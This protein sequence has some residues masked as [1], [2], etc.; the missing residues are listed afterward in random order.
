MS[1]SSSSWT[2]ENGL[3]PNLIKQRK[4][5]VEPYFVFANAE[6]I[7]EELTFTDIDNA[8]D[9]AAWFLTK[10]LAEDEKKFFYM[11]RMDIR[12]FIWVLAAM[13]TGKCVSEDPRTRP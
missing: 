8:S 1:S 10:N 3:L 7:T 5:Q 12:Y 11:G 6:G 2:T 9:R 4:S 13:K